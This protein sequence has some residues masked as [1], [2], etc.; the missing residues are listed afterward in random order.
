MM[1]S[2]MRRRTIRKTVIA[3]PADLLADVDRAVSQIHLGVARCIRTN[4]T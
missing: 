4:M 1:V 2:Q 3:L